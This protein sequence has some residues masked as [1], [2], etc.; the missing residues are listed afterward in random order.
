MTETTQPQEPNEAERP[1][2]DRR[3]FLKRAAIGAGAVGAVVLA[4][5]LVRD[6]GAD[7]ESVAAIEELQAGGPVMIYVRDASRGEAVIMADDTERV[8]TDRALVSH[9]LQAQGRHL[10]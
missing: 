7:P 8:V 6:S 2:L 9:L 4:P 10:T 5:T 3:T 1:P